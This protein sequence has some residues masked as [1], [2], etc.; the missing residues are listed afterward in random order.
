MQRPI[1]NIP[2]FQLTQNLLEF[3]FLA[4]NLNLPIVVIPIDPSYNIPL[5]ILFLQ[6]QT[7]PL[8]HYPALAHDH[9][10][11]GYAFSLFHIMC[12]YQDGM[13]AS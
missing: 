5:S 2:I 6:L 1:L 3:I 12:R 9:D 7:A 4:P 11:I 8:G 13:S 10:A